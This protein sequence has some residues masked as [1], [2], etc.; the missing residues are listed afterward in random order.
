MIRN[1]LRTAAAFIFIMM[2]AAAAG[3][4]DWFD[5]SKKDEPAP[6]ISKEEAVGTWERKYGTSVETYIFYDNNSY[7]HEVVNADGGNVYTRGKFKVSANKL[8]LTS[9]DTNVK[10]EHLTRF[11][12]EKTMKWGEGSSEIKF[13]KK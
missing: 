5:S 8:V 13:T 10:K 7:T 6:N 12:D 11:P 4:C 1:F 2:L 3:G 9:D